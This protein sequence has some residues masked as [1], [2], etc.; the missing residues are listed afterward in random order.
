M[1]ENGKNLWLQGDYTGL[2]LCC[3]LFNVVLVFSRS[4]RLFYFS[5]KS[6]HILTTLVWL[7]FR[8]VSLGFYIRS[9]TW[10]RFLQRCL[11]CGSPNSHFLLRLHGLK[12]RSEVVEDGQNHRNWFCPS[13]NNT[14]IIIIIG[15]FDNTPNVLYYLNFTN[16]LTDRLPDTSPWIFSC[17]YSYC[18]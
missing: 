7:L 12:F 2:I 16:R 4:G 18:L 17:F 8:V 5:L 13:N 11:F 10:F 3:L 1:Y 9:L 14:L 6:F 15:V